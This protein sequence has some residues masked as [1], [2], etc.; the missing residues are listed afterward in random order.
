MTLSDRTGPLLVWIAMVCVVQVGGS[1]LRMVRIRRTVYNSIDLIN[2]AKPKGRKKNRFLKIKNFIF[3]IK[4]FVHTEFDSLPFLFSH[5]NVFLLFFCCFFILIE[6]EEMYILV[7]FQERI[8]KKF[9][10]SLRVQFCWMLAGRDET[11]APVSLRF[12][13]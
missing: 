13:S 10:E 12:C 1:K 8:G 9:Q 7:Y 3:L 6:S 11:V 5:S 2:R 4:I